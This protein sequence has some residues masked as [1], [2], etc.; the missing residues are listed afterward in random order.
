MKGILYPLTFA[1]LAALSLFSFSLPIP[2]RAAE[3]YGK[4][5]VVYHFNGDDPKI[6]LGGLKNMQNHINAVGL[7]NLQITAVVHSKAW[8]ML[9]KQKTTEDLAKMLQKLTGQGLVFRLC[10]NTVKAHNM[11]PDNLVIKVMVVPAGVAELTKLQQEGY[12]YIKP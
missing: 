1:L 3:G 7:D 9:D 6:N 8:V 12:A 11:D 2:A 10:N 5:K 4:Q